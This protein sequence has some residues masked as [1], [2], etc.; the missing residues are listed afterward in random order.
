M[1][2]AKVDLAAFWVFD[3]PKKGCPW[4]VKFDNNRAYMIELT[5]AA[6]RRWNLSTQGS[7]RQ[8]AGTGRPTIKN[9]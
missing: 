1:E 6:N 3:L 7:E 4:S 2:Q 8:T 5:A 9:H